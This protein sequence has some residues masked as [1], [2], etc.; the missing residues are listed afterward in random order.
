MKV[1][2]VNTFIDIAVLQ[3]AINTWGYAYF[4]LGEWPQWAQDAVAAAAN[5]TLA[6][7][8]MTTAVP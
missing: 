8:L 3:L 2:F 5:K 1:G 6:G 4:N 7:D